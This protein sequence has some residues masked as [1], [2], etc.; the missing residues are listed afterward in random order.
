[1]HLACR[2]RIQGKV[3][4]IVPAELKACLGQGVVPLLRTWMSFGQVSRVGSDFVGNDA[5]LHV[6]SIRQAQMLLW[7][8]V[9]EHGSP[10]STDV[11]SAN[12]AGDVIVARSD[13]GGQWAQGVEWCLMA[14]VQLLAHVVGDLVQGHVSRSLVHHLDTLLPGALGQIALHL[15]FAE[16]GFVICILDAPGT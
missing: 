12:G 7:G 9:A 4:L 5:S 11:G 13:V 2:H 15:Q 1:M 8:H 10:H 16:L 3:E 6:F 14:P